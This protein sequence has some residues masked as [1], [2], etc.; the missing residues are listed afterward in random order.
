MVAQTKSVITTVG[1][2]QL[3]GADLLA[4]CVA[5]G[6]RLFRPLRRAGVDATDDRCA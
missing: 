5:A 4:A 1:P 3:Y 6:G 2:Y